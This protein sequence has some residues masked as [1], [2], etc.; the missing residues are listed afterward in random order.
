MNMCIGTVVGWPSPSI[1]KL[2]ATD[3]PTPLT[4]PEISTLVTMTAVGYVL[5]PFVNYLIQLIFKP[6]QLQMV[7]DYTGNVIFIDNAGAHL[8]MS[9]AINPREVNPGSPV[10][11]MRVHEVDTWDGIR[12]LWCI[13]CRATL[14][15]IFS[16][17]MCLICT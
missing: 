14:Y 7:S 10:Y 16:R 17:Y 3:Y 12:G 13:S 1:V 2:M 9:C 4:V 15:M 6:A 11:V 8:C 5:G